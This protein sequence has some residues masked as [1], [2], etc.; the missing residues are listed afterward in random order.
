MKAVRL[1]KIRSFIVRGEYLPLS[2]T[3]YDEAK[4]P[5]ASVGS[6]NKKAVCAANGVSRLRLYASWKSPYAPLIRE[7]SNGIIP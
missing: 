4:I 6:Q 1:K 5:L 2:L 7:S 3:G